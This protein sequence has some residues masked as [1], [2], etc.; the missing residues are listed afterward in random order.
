[1]RSKEHDRS[2]IFAPSLRE[3]Y[4]AKE[5]VFNHYNVHE[6]NASLFSHQFQVRS[7]YVG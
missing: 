2:D 3:V 4:S 7:S 5:N 1:M 6:E